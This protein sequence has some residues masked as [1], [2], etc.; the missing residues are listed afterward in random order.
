MSRGQVF[1][2]FSSECYVY[3]DLVYFLREICVANAVHP[4]YSQHFR[5]HLFTKLYTAEYCMV[6]THKKSNGE[7]LLWYECY[8]IVVR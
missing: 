4:F 2:V 7:G 5:W 1:W 6:K 8:V 3:L